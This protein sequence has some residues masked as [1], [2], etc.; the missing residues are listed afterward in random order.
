MKRFE[1]ILEKMI[2]GFIRA[3]GVVPNGLAD[4]KSRF[5]GLMWFVLDQKHRRIMLENLAIA[6]SEWL[7]PA[8]R[9]ALARRVMIRL[10]R[11]LFEIGRYARFSPEELQSRFRVEGAEHLRDALSQG[12]GVLALTAH[13]GN[14][15]F[16]PIGAVLLD[17]PLSIVYRPLDFRPLDRVI[18]RLRTRFG[19]ELIP[20]SRGA[21]R[22]ILRALAK[23]RIVAMLMDQ[24]VDWYEGVWMDF[25]GKPAC[26]NKGMATIAVKTG[27]PV[28]PVFM[29]QDG[30]NRWVI[31]FQPALQLSVTGDKTSDIESNTALFTQVIEAMIRRHPDQWFWVHQ[32]WKTA[33]ACPV[34]WDAAGRRR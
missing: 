27:A 10:M 2:Y 20:S 17:V 18:A 7:N 25:F 8:E 9:S 4:L 21:M 19:A 22:G 28:V 11:M 6:F 3:M 24:N 16:L 32:R 12:K 23:G 29:L 14:W 15:E 13:F 5:W 33:N 30:D 34:P 31:A 26:T 1:T